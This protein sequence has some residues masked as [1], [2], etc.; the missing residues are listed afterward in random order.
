MHVSDLLIFYNYT[1]QQDTQ[2]LHIEKSD[3]GIIYKTTDSLMV[4]QF[5]TID[6][7]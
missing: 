2:T 6:I 4:M 3:P 1:T 5:T 7:A